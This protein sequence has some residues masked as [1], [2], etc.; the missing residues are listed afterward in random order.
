MPVMAPPQHHRRQDQP[1]QDGAVAAMDHAVPQ[2]QCTHCHEYGN[3]QRSGEQ[4]GVVAQ[5]GGH[6]HGRHAAVVHQRNA[7]PY[8]HAGRQQP[9]Q[10]GLRGQQVAQR[11]PGRKQPG[12][13]GCQGHAQVVVHIHRQLQGQH[14]DEM[15]G[16]DAQA[17]RAAAAQQCHLPLEA[18]RSMHAGLHQVQRQHRGGNR[19]GNRQNHQQ[20]VMPH[21]QQML[22]LALQQKEIRKQRDSLVQWHVCG[23]CNVASRSCSAA[24]SMAHT[25]STWRCVR[26]A[27]DGTSLGSSSASLGVGKKGANPVGP[28]GCPR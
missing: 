23:T 19:H 28:N 11:Q 27:Q 3:G 5:I 10:A 12:E 21:M 4:P 24:H 15:H 8:H 1:L 9:E 13:H 18:T 7:H 22:R 2:H 16:P 25:V 20:R 26:G 17:Q 6:V 14:A